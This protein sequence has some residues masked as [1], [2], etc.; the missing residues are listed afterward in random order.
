MNKKLSPSNP[1][2]R[3]STVPGGVFWQK[4]I[5]HRAAGTSENF[6]GINEILYKVDVDRVNLIQKYISWSHHTISI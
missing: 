3:L 2:P 4:W 1:N 6:F 5:F